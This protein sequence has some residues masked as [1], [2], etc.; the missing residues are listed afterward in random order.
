MKGKQR[1]KK[2]LLMMLSGLLTI[3]LASCNT[4]TTNQY[5]ARAL[6]TMTWQ[7]NYTGSPLH[8]KRG[9][10][11]EFS[12]SSLV[13][14]NGQKPADAVIG[15]DDKGLWWSTLPPKPSLDEIEQRQ[16]KP[17]KA[18][19]PELLR[20]VTYEIT[21]QNSGQTLT[22]PTNY[23]VY[24]QVVKAYPESKSLRLTLGANDASVTKA[25]PI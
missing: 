25:E 14:S 24:R 12:T 17:E 15:P 5:E 19:K 13:N 16:K 22:L 21:Y 9:R 10:F 18:G 2:L 11:E 1:Y 7:V 23:E 6:T 4:V 3:T 8:S 20:T